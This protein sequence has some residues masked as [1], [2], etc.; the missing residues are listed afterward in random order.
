MIKA[1]LA[2]NLK[3]LL[4]FVEPSFAHQCR[5]LK[6]FSEATQGIALK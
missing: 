1:F 3:G 2:I 4:F 6:L 5:L